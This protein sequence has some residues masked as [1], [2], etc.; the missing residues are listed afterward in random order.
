MKKTEQTEGIERK[1]LEL[2]R[3]NWHHELGR[4]R[5]ACVYQQLSQLRFTNLS[6]AINRR[7]DACAPARMAN[8]AVNSLNFKLISRITVVA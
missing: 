2:Y 1:Y 3:N 4:R 7:R 6:F 5:L 8:S